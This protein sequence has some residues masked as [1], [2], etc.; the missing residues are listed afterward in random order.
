VLPITDVRLAD[1][2]SATKLDPQLQWLR[3]FIEH[4]WPT[5]IINVPEI[6]HDFWKVRDKWYIEGD[7]ILFGN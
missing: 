6:L 1:L 5:K 7:L 3:Y 2:Q 4:G